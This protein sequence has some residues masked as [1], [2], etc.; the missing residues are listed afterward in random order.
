M[1]STLVC[2]V[3]DWIKSTTNH[4][5]SLLVV[6]IDQT[7]ILHGLFAWEILSLWW[8]QQEALTYGWDPNIVIYPHRLGHYW[9]RLVVTCILDRHTMISHRI[10][11]ICLI[12]WSKSHLIRKTMTIVI[13]LVK[14]DI[15]FLKLEYVNWSHNRLIYNLRIWEVILIGW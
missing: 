2:M 9:W 15:C 12:G 3:I 13:H 4:D 7:I 10:E 6:M 14:F 8:S 5:I 11:T 1:V